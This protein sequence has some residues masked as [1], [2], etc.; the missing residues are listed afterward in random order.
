MTYSQT[1][2]DCSFEQ[3]GTHMRLGRVPVQSL[4]IVRPVSVEGVEYVS[5]SEAA[6]L[7]GLNFNLLYVRIISARPRWRHYYFLDGKPIPCF[8]RRARKKKLLWVVYI[9]EHNATRNRY[10]GYTWDFVSRK[11]QHLSMLRHKRHPSQKLQEHYDQ[12]PCVS[13][14]EWTV[15]VVNGKDSALDLE[16]K[17][18]DQAIEDQ[19]ILNSSFN[20][21]SNISSAFGRADV[22]EKLRLYRESSDPALRL[23]RSMRSTKGL[24]TRWSKEGSREAIQGSGNP[25]AKPVIA[26]GQE[27]GSVIEASKALD[28]NQKTIFNRVRNAKFPDYR[29]P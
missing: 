2:P 7:L 21:R 1:V 13:A 24:Q 23:K 8:K 19:T 4:T 27:Y 26:A 9:L 20:S 11:S 14:W 17:L 28:V 16:Q 10:I 3:S 22:Q 6:R 12:N 18:I 5:I 29:F 25:F 15:M